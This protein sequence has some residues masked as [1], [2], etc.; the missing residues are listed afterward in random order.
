MTTIVALDTQAGVNAEIRSTRLLFLIVGFGVA[1]WA[2]LVPFVAARAGLDA[3]ALG[4]LLLCLGI[5]SLVA[6]PVAGVLAGRWG[7]RTVLAACV[8]TVCAALAIL[9][10]SGTVPVLALALLGLGAGLGGLDCLM[11]LQAVAVE[12]RSGRPMMSGFH[13]L[14]SLGCI[15]GAAGVAAL[16]GLGLTPALATLAV[17]AGI[18]AAFVGALPGLLSV[19]PGGGPAFAVPRGP[20]LGIGLLCFV[21]FLTEGAALDWSAVFL[22][23]ERGFDLAQ[24]GLGYAAFSLTMTVGRLTGDALVRRIGRARIVVFGG[25]TAAAG[26]CVVTLVP[27]W[28]AALLGYALVGAGCANIVPVLFTMAARQG[29]MPER[30]A[31]PAVTT[32]GYAGVL[33]GPAAIGF[34]A[35]A[36]GLTTAFLVIALLLVGV[37]LGGR[38]ID[39]RT[40]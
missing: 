39:F 23:R 13:G 30:L 10:T 17:V 28:P 1:A 27:G 5:G 7:A 25:L 8:A 20:V 34:L 18:L 24:A 38:R 36:T 33:T 26:L 4:G 19:E 2:P 35:H 31:I 15:G 21:V 37:A 32:L 22:V 12:R 3:A 29:A 9:S 16:L 40:G 6:M 11:N 14:Y